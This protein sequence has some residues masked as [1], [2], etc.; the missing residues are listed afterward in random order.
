MFNMK[1]VVKF[2]KKDNYEV[3]YEYDSILLFGKEI[4]SINFK[5]GI[6]V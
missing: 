1:H 6:L 2:Y 3:V 4:W 5:E